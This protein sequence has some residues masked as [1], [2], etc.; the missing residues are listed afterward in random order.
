M[1]VFAIAVLAWLTKQSTLA[2]MSK[3]VLLLSAK[4]MALDFIR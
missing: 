1:A 2:A 3:D 4:V